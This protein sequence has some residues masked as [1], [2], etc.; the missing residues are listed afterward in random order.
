MF[1]LSWEGHGQKK[2]ESQAA[3]SY[4]HDAHLFRLL[5]E[6]ESEKGKETQFSPTVEATRESRPK[7][8]ARQWEKRTASKPTDP[9]LVKKSKKGDTAR[10]DT[11]RVAKAGAAPEDA[12]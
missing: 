6:D 5:D 1:S 7:I 4:D 11:G 8:S 3:F 12:I 10:A 2:S 9:T